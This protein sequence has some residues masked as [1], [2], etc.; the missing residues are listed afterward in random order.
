LQAAA[1]IGAVVTGVLARRR[2]EEM[3]GL[4]RKLRHINAELRRQREAQD[5]LLSAVGG[6]A[7][8]PRT[9]DA[10]RPS[11]GGEGGEGGGAGM[12]A[13]AA[14][15]ALQRRQQELQQERSLLEAALAGPAA[16]HPSEG[17]GDQRL[18]LARAR[19]R[20]AQCIRCIHLAGLLRGAASLLLLL[21][22][23]AHLSH[24][25]QHARSL[26]RSVAPRRLA[27]SSLT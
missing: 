9:D 13:A 7:A 26:L 21:P 8:A 23:S 14:L 1:L 20:I 10:A 2:R 19:R 27:H 11:E 16:A 22:V 6:V 25:S 24:L 12:Q 5:S 18:S 3:Q 17:F 4:N 15:E